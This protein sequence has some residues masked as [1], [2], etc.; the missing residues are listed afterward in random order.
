MC[1]R[2]RTDNRYFFFGLESIGTVLMAFAEKR[3]KSLGRHF[4]FIISD[5]WITSTL[6]QPLL[7]THHIL[8]SLQFE[9][10]SIQSEVPQI[11]NQ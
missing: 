11:T 2:L 1:K 6:L 5:K 10:L 7:Q 9:W 8:L 4:L 3:E